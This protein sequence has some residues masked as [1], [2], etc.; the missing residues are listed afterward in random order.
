MTD[1]RRKIAQRIRSCR[2]AAGW[3]VEETARRLSL[4]SSETITG[5]R[6]GNWEQ[7]IRTPKIEQFVELGALFKTSGA[8]LAGLTDNDG[9]APE[10]GMYCVPKPPGIPTAAGVM[11]VGDDSLAYRLTFLEALKLDRNQLLPVAMPDNS[12]R[13]VI[14][15]SD[16][17]LIDCTVTSVTRDDLFALMINGRLWIRWI[18]QDIGGDYM[19]QA[20]D[21]VSYPDQAMTAEKLAALHI[22]GRVKITS[23]IR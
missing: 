4:I 21:R 6:Y 8:Y 10:E 19:I 11:D 20:E 17:V 16:L 22:L 14:E 23:H 9:S 12:M 15:E 13:G 18:R 2:S 7:Q 5:S 1:I 3:T